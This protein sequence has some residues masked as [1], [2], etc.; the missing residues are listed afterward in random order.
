MYDS[1]GTISANKKF[2]VMTVLSTLNIAIIAVILFW[3]FSSYRSQYDYYKDQIVPRQKFI[4]AIKTAFMIDGLLFHFYNYIFTGDTKH[5]DE[6]HKKQEFV[7]ETIREYKQLANISFEEDRALN[8]IYFY[9][10]VYAQ[11]LGLIIR[12]RTE[13]DIISINEIRKYLYFNQ[14]DTVNA[15][16]FI[17]SNFT[18][19]ERETGT[20]M[21]DT[22]V[23]FMMML[24]LALAILLSSLVLLNFFFFVKPLNSAFVELKQRDDELST[25]LR[26]AKK[27]Q[28]S[29][30]SKDTAG[31]GLC[32]FYT[33]YLPLAYIGGDYY[34]IL[35]YKPGR[36]RVFL[37]DASGHGVQAALITLLIKG[38]YD[39]LKSWI[40][41]PSDIIRTLNDE[42]VN[43]QS[44]P[45]FFTCVIFDIDIRSQEI[46][47]CSAGHPDQYLLTR[48]TI[49]PLKSTSR[50]IGIAPNTEYPSETIPFSHF[51]R[52][53]LLTDGIF[54]EFN[55]QQEIWEETRTKEIVLKNYAKPVEKII[56]ALM[57][58]VDSFLAGAPRK[59]DITLIGIA[60]NKPPVPKKAVSRKK[61][62][63]SAN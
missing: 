52:L 45:S 56:D 8:V 6:F 32:R 23:F 14:E 7:F 41:F 17:E 21:D 59:D 36:F 30:L 3:S 26:L 37:A 12:F 29:I 55:R 50:P 51:D 60:F 47:Y 58:E 15:F 38:E 62:G 27:V 61:S 35:E 43:N 39:K 10:G 31:S 54:E 34:D 48:N 42:F 11:N 19:M 46:V 20:E 53:I 4:S 18:L 22:L 5:V 25:D 9:A 49:V 63:L 16:N 33:K 2:A 24:I 1:H 13:A 44:L 57:E 28:L 40:D